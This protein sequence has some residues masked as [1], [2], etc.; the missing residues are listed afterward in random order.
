MAT[1]DC[2]TRAANTSQPIDEGANL[3]FPRQRGMSLV[4]IQDKFTDPVDIGVL[5]PPAVVAHT[6]RRPYLV[7][8]SWLMLLGIRHGTLDDDDAIV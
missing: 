5:G 7:E 1:L 8:Q 6:N 3:R 2:E 4:V